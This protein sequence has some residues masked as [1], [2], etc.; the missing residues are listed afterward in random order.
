MFAANQPP[1]ESLPADADSPLEQCDIAAAVRPAIRV[2]SDFVA[3]EL[4]EIA[5]EQLKR[6][7]M[8]GC[9]VS[10]RYFGKIQYWH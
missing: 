10:F 2:R 8:S 5:S 4:K 7:L 6:I 9:Q 1:D 3:L